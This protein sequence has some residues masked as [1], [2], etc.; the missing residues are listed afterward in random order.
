MLTGL[1]CILRDG[2]EES[3]GLGLESVNSKSEFKLSEWYIHWLF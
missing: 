3:R 1:D 2:F